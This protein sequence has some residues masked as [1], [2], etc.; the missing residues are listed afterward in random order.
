MTTE[1]T[2]HDARTC[3]CPLCGVR[4]DITNVACWT[5]YRETSRLTPGRYLLR[6]GYGVTLDVHVVAALDQLRQARAGI[7]AARLAK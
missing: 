4:M 5:C 2:R 6:S 1:P 3:P 7:I